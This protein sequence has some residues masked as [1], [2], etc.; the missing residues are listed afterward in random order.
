MPEEL[1]NSENSQPSN[2]NSQEF[3]TEEEKNEL[4]RKLIDVET[5]NGALNS[6]KIINSRK[7]LELKSELIKE[8]LT[9]L[10][11]NGVD[12]NDQSSIS[13][14]L[15]KLEQQNPDLRELFEMAFNEL[16]GG[17]N[18]NNVNNI[19]ENQPMRENSGISET[20]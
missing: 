8:I 3:A 11:K 7:L 2:G 9:E 10:Q 6:L 15:D 5:K 18:N 17:E 1:I 12:L 4:K 13:E 14:F 20:I 16:E 19:Y